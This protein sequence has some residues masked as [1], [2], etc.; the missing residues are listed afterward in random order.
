MG[1]KRVLIYTT[2]FYPENFKVNDI[3][4]NLA[5]NNFDVTVVTAIPNYPVG[6]YFE[7][8]GL[9][10]KRSEIL[11]GVKVIRLPI[12]PRGSGSAI[13]LLLNYSSFAVVAFLHAFYL[14]FTQKFDKIFVHH[15][16]PIF[17]GIPAIVIK[18]IQKIKIYFWNLDFWPEIVVANTNIRS[19]F[20]FNAVLWL[21]RFIYKHVDIM[22]IGSNEYRSLMIER[23]VL[24]EKIIFFPNWAEKLFFEDSKTDLPFSLPKG[25]NVVYA[26]NIGGS[27]DFESVIKSVNL[28][29][30]Q[31]VNWIFVG[32]GRKRSWI[33]ENIKTMGLESKVFLPGS[34]DIKYM[35]SLFSK[36]DLLLLSLV[37]EPIY[38]IPAK[39]Q[40]YMSSGTPIVGMLNGGG[41]DLIKEVSCGKS[42]NAGDYETLAKNILE[43]KSM[44]EEERKQLGKNGFE[45]CMTYF[46]PN[47]CL[48]TLSD[49]LE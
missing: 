3:A 9:F 47:K 27:Q 42:C 11:N 22:L 48:N 29:K 39:L 41:N 18:K 34:F 36:A 25:F 24:K 32:D 17:I 21:V 46:N 26:G 2:Y 28:L 44:S 7:G 15:V 38:T 13:R 6:Q 16:S 14:G 5:N 20:F 40:A 35:P 1:K 12:I 31:D 23:G 33:E 19:P 45:Y 10:K 49:I 43:I 4:F 8:Y 37:D 30:N